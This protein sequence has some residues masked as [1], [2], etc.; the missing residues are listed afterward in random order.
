MKFLGTFRGR[1]LAVLAVL[2]IATLSVQYYLNLQRQRENQRLLET[3]EQAFLA[4]IALGFN[5]LTSEQRLADFVKTEGR[6]FYGR[7]TTEKIKDILIINSDWMVNDTLSGDYLPTPGEGDELVYVPL[8]SLTDLPPLMEGRDQL[9]ADFEQFP[10]TGQTDIHNPEGE[11][12]AIPIETDQGRWYVMVILKKDNTASL[13]RAAQPLV[14]TLAILLISILATIALVWRFTRP[15]A[16]LSKAARRVGRGELDFRLSYED[17][18]DEI[19]QLT[20]QFNLMTSELQK[21]RDLQE[22]LQEAEKSAVV[23][24]LAS[25]IAHEIRN[26]LNYINLSLDHLT[27]KFAPS[28]GEKSA[29]FEKLTGQ[30]KIEVDR[31][32][33]QVSDFLSYSR[34]VRLELE[35]VNLRPVLEDCLRIVEPQAVEQEVNVSLVERDEVPAVRADAKT[36]RSVFTNLFINAIQAMEKGGGFLNVVMYHNGEEVRVEVRDTGIGIDEADLEK[37]FQPYFS[38]KETGTGLGLAIVKKIVE[39]HGGRIGTESQ[40]DVGTTIYVDLP[41]A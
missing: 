23:G 11:A 22:Q 3:Q 2:L 29:D 21:T 41:V 20:T 4:G 39:D 28:D 15:I 6:P 38:T 27:K 24:R 12:H 1:L 10:N 31:I 7:S 8:R 16:D 14:Y 19:G 5:S 32:N 26:P 33:R 37:I 25:A 9:G 40:I 18:T 17:R 34:P 13:F 36:L 35:N 30:L